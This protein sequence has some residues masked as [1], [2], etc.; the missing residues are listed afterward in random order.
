MEEAAD[1]VNTVLYAGRQNE[2]AIGK[3]LY[4]LKEERRS[5]L[6]HYYR[7]TISFYV[8]LMLH[9]TLSCQRLSTVRCD[10][11]HARRRTSLS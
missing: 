4:V 7:Q 9:P 10:R 2:A 11:T 1:A 3:C 8:R 5:Y 6:F